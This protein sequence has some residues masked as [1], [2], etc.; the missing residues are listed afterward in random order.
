MDPVT[1]AI[2]IGGLGAHIAISVVKLKSCWDKIQDA[3]EDV[4]NLITRVD[5]SSRILSDIE[6]D[7]T[8][9]PISP[10]LLDGSTTSECVKQCSR[11]ADRLRTV[12]NDTMRDT[13]MSNQFKKKWNS[14]KWLLK[15]DKIK[16]VETELQSC[17]AFLQLSRNLDQTSVRP[18][19]TSC[20]TTVCIVQKLIWKLTRLPGPSSVFS[21]ISSA[22]K[23]HKCFRLRHNLT[24]SYTRTPSRITQL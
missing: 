10:L 22:Q 21:Q 8:Q 11:A 1:G 13:H 15:M 7:Q 23:C 6:I 14:T 24:R 9:N 16:K 5:I 3:P 4:Q 20:T 18:I 12:I 17:I 19:L 2:T